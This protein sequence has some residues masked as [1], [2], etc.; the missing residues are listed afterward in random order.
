[1]RFLLWILAAIGLY[2]IWPIIVLFF[3]LTIIYIDSLSKVAF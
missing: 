3:M 1:M 2:A